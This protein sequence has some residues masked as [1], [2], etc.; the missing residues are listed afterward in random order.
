ML[1]EVNAFYLNSDMNSFSENLVKQ[2]FNGSNFVTVIDNAGNT[3][4]I[5]LHPIAEGKECIWFIVAM[6]PTAA[7]C[8]IFVCNRRAS[9][10]SIAGNNPTIS[11]VDIGSGTEGD[12]GDIKIS[13]NFGYAHLIIIGT[14]Q[15]SVAK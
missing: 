7:Q 15:T 5:Q 10:V 12:N 8:Q 9:V 3:D 6:Y 14:T 13:F 11:K 2:G 1:L 4:T